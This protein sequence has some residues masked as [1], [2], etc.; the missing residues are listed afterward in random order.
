METQDIRLMMK[1]L[2]SKIDEKLKDIKY[3]GDI[4]D[5]GNEVGY[6]VGKV[7]NMNEQDTNDFITGIKH[8]ISL[9][10]ETH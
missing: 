4:S 3:Q 7:L 8:G 1:L 5:L 2:S 6:C 9:T 10:N